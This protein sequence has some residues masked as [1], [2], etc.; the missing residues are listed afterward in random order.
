MGD[1][2]GFDPELALQQLAQIPVQHGAIHRDVHQLVL[3]ADPFQGPAIAELAR[4]QLPLEGRQGGPGLLPQPFV[5]LMG[6]AQQADTDEQQEDEPHQPEKNT[7]YPDHSTDPRER[8]SRSGQR[9]IRF[10]Q[11]TVQPP[12]ERRSR[13]GQRKMRF[14]QITAQTPA[15][16]AAAAAGQENRREE[17]WSAAGS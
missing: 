10:T 8:R 9:K 5:A 15:K 17:E 11:I 13:S 7:F 12:R 3:P 14:T 4:H 16:D 1:V 6:E 2:Q